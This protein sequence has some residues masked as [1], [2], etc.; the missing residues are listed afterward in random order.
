V[1]SHYRKGRHRLCQPGKTVAQKHDALK[2]V[3]GMNKKDNAL[4][5]SRLRTEETYRQ[6]LQRL[7][8]ALAGAEIGNWELDL[9]TQTA[10]RSLRHDQI[11]GYTELLPEWSYPLFLEHVHPD[12]RAR[13]DH[14]FQQS[15]TT[16]QD[17][18]FEC[19]IT[20]A[21]A[22]VRWIWAR[23]RIFKDDAG[24]PTHMLGMVGDI[25]EKKQAEEKLKQTA[26]E[27]HDLYNNAP[28]GYHSLDRDGLIVA[29]NDTELAWLGYRREEIIGKKR[30]GDLLTPDSRQI[31][32][33][34][35][36]RFKE[37]GWVQDLEMELIRK[38][39]TILPVALS[40]TAIKDAAGEY[41][42]SRSTVFDITARRRAAQ[43]LQTAYDE[44]EQ[45]V[46]Q[47][48]LELAE[49]N[50]ELHAQI[51]ER[52]R[53][54]EEI[55]KLNAELEQRVAERTAELKVA[56]DGLRQAKEEADKANRAKSIFLSNMS[57]EIRTPMNAIFGFAQLLQR[58][59]TL[60]P[61]QQEEVATI[62]R[63]SEHLL[64]LI[65]DILEMARIEAGRISLN[66]TAFS[67]QGLLDDLEMMF[68][69][70]ADAKGLQLLVE[71][72][73]SVPRHI[74]ADENKVRQIFIN[75]LDNAVKFTE[76]GGI[77]IRVRGEPVAGAEAAGIE[78]DE[79]IIRLVIEVEDTGRGISAEDQARLFQPFQ[80]AEGG[81]QS[82]GTGLGLTISRKFSQ[83][84]G[85]DLSV[86]SQVGEGSCFR[87]QLLVQPTEG[88]AV[89]APTKLRRVTGLQP[90]TGVVRV[91]IVDD[92]AHNRALLQKLLIPAGFVVEEARDGQEAL[93][94]FARWSPHVILMDMRMPNMDG[95]EAT[96]R[97]KATEAGQA[98]PIIAVTASA[99]AEA[100][101]A[102]RN[103][104]VDAY[105]RKPFR[106]ESLFAAL[107]ES[108]DL[109]YVYDDEEAVA[110]PD[111][112]P[113]SPEAVANLPGELVAR[114]RTATITGDRGHLLALLDEVADHDA[115]LAAT[116]H[117]MA[118][119]YAYEKLLAL[120]EKEAL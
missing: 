69:S 19:R 100:E 110:L 106:E 92:N 66:S 4:T 35:F 93:A 89:A 23:G 108:L 8:Q 76:R 34:N 87:C 103:A 54:E 42:A 102:I 37:R 109:Q 74:V 45:R 1:Y 118:S 101:Q 15:M 27:V 82:G 17:W 11:F 53:A 57:H 5:K 63:A 12:D 99:F 119:K 94:T 77:G 64:A 90:G 14:T 38:D 72:D 25:T 104:G 28:C 21:D 44:L 13:V 30:F 3:A 51:A 43:A 61:Q 70:R 65:N 56:N 120:L 73:E 81:T 75:L 26:A 60:T 115:P 98:T 10:H 55:L 20:R 47:R 116:L 33:Y 68:R 79:A 91:L 86:T 95:Y 96:R 78:T 58:D 83:M 39:G 88:A 62:S 31:F 18:Y 84:M 22:V 46:Q 50:E 6:R 7:R 2:Q 105:I 16:G 67:L 114:L 41:L 40:A 97:L 48:T 59:T 36:P 52:K 49:A 111:T 80:Q 85:G 29:I 24:Q 32:A 71:R 117:D 107:A 9:V 113:L 112:G